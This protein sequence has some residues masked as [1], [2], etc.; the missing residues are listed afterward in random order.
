MQLGSIGWM[1]KGLAGTHTKEIGPS[2]DF[3][4]EL[5]LTIFS[6]ITKLVTTPKI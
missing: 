6:A 1:L 3:Y 5:L 4:D 2:G